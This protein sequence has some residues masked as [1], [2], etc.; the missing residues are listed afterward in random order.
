MEKSVDAIMKAI[1]ESGQDKT[2]I[3]KQLKKA[4]KKLELYK[5]K[6]AYGIA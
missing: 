3:L 6:V 4:N 1:R 2:I 5:R